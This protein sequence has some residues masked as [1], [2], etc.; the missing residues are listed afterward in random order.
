MKTKS[1][2]LRQLIPILLCLFLL[3]MYVEMASAQSEKGLTPEHV[4]KIKS[5]GS[6]EVSP[7]GN[8]IAYTLRVQ[9]DPKKSNETASDH[10]YLYNRQSGSSV[11]Y[12][13][14]ADV[15]VVKFRPKHNSLTFLTRK[16]GDEATSLYE[17]ALDGGEARKI[18]SFETSIAG[19][20]WA[21]DGE[22]LAFMASEPV[23]KEESALPYEPEIYEENLV[24]RRGYITNVTQEDHEPHRVQVEGSIYQ[25]HWSPDGERL[26]IAVTP[27]PLVDDYYMHQQ[28]LIVDHAGEKVLGQ[29]D[30]EGKL[31]Q[32][33]WS[34]DGEHL[35]MIAGA[36]IHDPIDGRL[37][38]VSADGGT[39]QNLK[40]NYE[41]KFEQ[42]SWS[43]NSTLYYL[44][45]QGVW[46]TYGSINA[47]GY[48]MQTIVDTGGPILGE[49]SKAGND[50]FCS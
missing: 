38:V 46:S 22:H 34:P 20:D 4:A 36:N 1:L 43:D 25:I 11:P 15:G 5:V 13:T 45:S 30:H 18:Y 17:I 42:F 32:I 21:A 19:Y 40:P 41:G 27:T 12:F 31:G 24:Q 47:D 14:D 49:F 39:P 6:V 2:K 35:A 37:F 10:L 7:D 16:E 23:E 28:M 44:A 48:N 26:A 33:A 29:V 50:R 8:S 9:A 3:L